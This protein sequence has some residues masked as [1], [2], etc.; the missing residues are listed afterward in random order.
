MHNKQ[1]FN[2]CSQ[3]HARKNFACWMSAYYTA[4][5]DTMLLGKAGGNLT[6]CHHVLC[7]EVSSTY[8]LV[9]EK[10]RE[11]MTHTHEFAYS[12]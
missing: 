9:G 10:M 5:L 7:I 12:V 3:F 4:V 1:K 6:P 8:T 11:M 2:T